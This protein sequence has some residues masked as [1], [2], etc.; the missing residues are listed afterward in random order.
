MA[1]KPPLIFYYFMTEI[2][3]SK[4]SSSICKNCGTPI[5]WV[6]LWTSKKT[7]IDKKRI[8]IISKVKDDI[9]THNSGY[10]PH[11]ES[12]PDAGEF[13]NENINE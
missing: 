13:K 7:P 3:T 1:F 11:W 9:W 6:T 10:L 8:T 5:F 12:C 4:P 2:V